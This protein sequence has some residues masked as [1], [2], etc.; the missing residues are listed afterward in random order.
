MYKS[1]KHG[2]DEKELGPEGFFSSNQSATFIS[3]TGMRAEQSHFF[4]AFLRS[5]KN[6]PKVR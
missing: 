4:T 1:E 3:Q 2:R 5:I 6:R